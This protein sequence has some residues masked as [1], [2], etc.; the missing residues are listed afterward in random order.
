M[1]RSPATSAAPPAVMGVLILLVSFGSVSQNM[2]LP[3]MASLRADLSA[4]VWEAQLTLSVFLFGLACFQLV[5]GPLSDRFGRRP[6][7]LGAIALF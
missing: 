4:E 7:L 3:S 1:S 2:Y 5:S 6:V